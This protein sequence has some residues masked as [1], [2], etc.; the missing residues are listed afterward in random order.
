MRGMARREYDFFVYIAASPSRQL[1]V[2][3]TNSVQRR[4]GQHRAGTPGSY[5][6]R[7][8]IGRLVYYE[9]FQYVLNAIAREKEL[10]DWSRERKIALIESVNPTWEDLA[11]RFGVVVKGIQA[12]ATAEATATAKEEADSS[13]SLRNDN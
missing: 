9:H 7:Y 1:Y 13:A 8:R 4:M 3:V 2:G 6:G 11:E 12:K 10:K 5:T